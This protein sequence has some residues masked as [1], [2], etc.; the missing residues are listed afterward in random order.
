MGAISASMLGIASEVMV[1]KRRAS[2]PWLVMSSSWRRATP[3]HTT[4]VSDSRMTTVAPAT[5]RNT[6]RLKVRP[7]LILGS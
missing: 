3:I 7:T 1:R 2:W 5:W 4:L 6:Y